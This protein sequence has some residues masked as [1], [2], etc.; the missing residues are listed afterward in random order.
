MT[1]YYHAAKAASLYLF[2]IANDLRPA[3]PAPPVAQRPANMLYPP[4]GL[5]QTAQTR[6]RQNKVVC[7]T[8]Y[9]IKLILYVVLAQRHRQKN[10]YCTHTR[11]RARFWFPS[12]LIYYFNYLKKCL[13]LCASPILM[14]LCLCSG[15]LCLS[16]PS[17]PKGG[18]CGL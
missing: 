14:R 3:S 4:S 13:C 9:L 8:F 18:Y 5:S 12:I 17:V 16:V 15:R 1:K 10:T 6:H 7:A 2:V 11:A